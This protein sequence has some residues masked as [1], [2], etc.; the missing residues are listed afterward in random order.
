LLVPVRLRLEID[1]ANLLAVGQQGR[2]EVSADESPALV[3]RNLPY[4]TEPD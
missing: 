2:D 1:S 3:T 4:M